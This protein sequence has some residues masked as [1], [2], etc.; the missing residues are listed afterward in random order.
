MK[1]F[2]G[3]A[4]FCALMVLVG[5]A[6]G[7]TPEPT[8]A[9]AAA[10]RSGWIAFEAASGLYVISA[11]GGRPSKIPGTRP[12]DGNPV[13]SPDGRRLSFERQRDGDWDVYV[14]N[15][16][17]T[18]LRQLTFSPWDDDFARWAPHGRSLAF[19]SAR[20]G[21]TEVYVI[22]VKGGAARRATS[23]GEY[24]DWTSDRRIM[25]AD[26]GQLFTVR[27]YGAD[28][29]LLRRQPSEDVVAAQVSNDGQKIVYIHYAGLYIARVDGSD[30]RRLT[31]SPDDDDATW[32]PDDQW[33]AF[34]KGFSDIYVVR[35]DGSEQTRL[36]SLGN[37]CCP[38][39]SATATGPR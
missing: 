13:W 30:S 18:G 25:F 20:R 37:A 23:P 38:D 39:W 15:A 28:R 2:L 5:L 21:Q 12:G 1:S 17:G 19:Q 34:D 3:P 16:D 10:Q 36:T 24:P 8:D 9:R 32:S 7:G 35:A 4:S 33:V 14:M 31:S 27:P 6:L 22:S 29:R 26:D 11:N